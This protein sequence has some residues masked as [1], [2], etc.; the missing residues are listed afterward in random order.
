MQCGHG[1]RGSF[2]KKGSRI[3]TYQ[4]YS[5]S[6]NSL[7]ERKLRKNLVHVLLTSIQDFNFFQLHNRVHTSQYDIT[8]KEIPWSERWTSYD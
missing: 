3:A 8:E 6:E 7:L 4:D 5:R 1:I 2:R